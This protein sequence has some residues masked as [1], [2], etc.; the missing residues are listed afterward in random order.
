[1]FELNFTK[2]TF[3]FWFIIFFLVIVILLIFG[4]LVGVYIF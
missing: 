2:E 4:I 3:W 1:M